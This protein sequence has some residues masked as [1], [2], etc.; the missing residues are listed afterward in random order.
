MRNISWLFWIK[1]WVVNEWPK[2]NHVILWCVGNGMLITSWFWEVWERYLL[3]EN[4]FRNNTCTKRFIWGF[5]KYCIENYATILSREINKWMRNFLN[6]LW[7][8][9][10]LKKMVQMVNGILGFKDP[11][12]W[13]LGFLEENLNRGFPE[14]QWNWRGFSGI[15]Q[16]K[17]TIGHHPTPENKIILRH[18]G[19]VFQSCHMLKCIF[20]MQMYDEQCW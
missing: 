6:T 20:H 5:W 13:S 11:N 16:E 10:S 8:L 12:I 14:W 15:S 2:I 7:Y 4:D 17:K 19:K 3:E 18:G 1:I 9:P